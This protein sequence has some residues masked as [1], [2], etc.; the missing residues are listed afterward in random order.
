VLVFG[1][2]PVQAQTRVRTPVRIPDV[3]GYKTLR[4][5]FHIHT[6]FSDGSVWPNIRSEEAWREG[7]DA[8]AITDH[9]EYQ[10]HKDDLPTN[11]ERSYEIAQPHGEMLDIIVIRGSE[12]TRDMPP[13]HLNAIFLTEVNPVD[14]EDWRDAIRTAHEQGAFIFWNHPGWQGQQPDSVAK[15]YAEH[16]ELVERDMLNGI[17]VVNAREYYP[18]AHRWCIEKKLTMLSNSDIHNPLNLDYHV[19][20]G[21]HRPLTLVFAREK[22]AEAI[23]E[24]LFSRRTAVYSGEVLVGDEE[25]LRPIFFR[26][27]EVKNPSVTVHGQRSAYIQIRNHSDITYELNGSNELEEISVPDRLVLSAGKTVLLGIAGT[28]EQRS[29]KKRFK[30]SYMVD[31]LK[32]APDHGMPVEFDV[33]VTFVPSEE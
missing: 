8:I 32:V 24:A 30:L 14:T 12:V 19:H 10:P 17:E 16:T 25:F 4:C 3:P 29:G 5:D 22:S 13:G 18:E 9:I 23:K 20:A 7:L 33:E 15:W 1:L 2:G 21:D 26:S 28:S 6:V 27:L 31:N 11:H